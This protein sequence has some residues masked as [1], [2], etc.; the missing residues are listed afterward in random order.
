LLYRKIYERIDTFQNKKGRFSG[1][2]SSILQKGKTMNPLYELTPAN[3]KLLQD[4]SDHFRENPTLAIKKLDEILAT[5][6]NLFVYSF[7]ARVLGLFVDIPK[8]ILD[9]IDEGLS[10]DATCYFLLAQKAQVF[11]VSFLK[12]DPEIAKAALQTAMQCSKQA[13]FHFTDGAKHNKTREKLHEVTHLNLSLEYLNEFNSEF[14]LQNVAYRIGLLAETIDASAKAEK[15]SAK[16]EK[17]SSDAAEAL[18]KVEKERTR[19]IELLGLFTAVIA[20]IFS[21]IHFASNLKT[22]PEAIIAIIGLGA[23][24]LLFLL[25]LHIVLDDIMRGKFHRGFFMILSIVI[26]LILLLVCA[27]KYVGPKETSI[28]KAS[29]PPATESEPVDKAPATTTN[30]SKPETARAR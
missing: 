8:K 2:F 14:S 10:L 25:T 11:S 17:A 19:T 7:K 1:I 21:S 26:V 5:Q 15:A 12:A 9:V 4:A 13:L 20:F 29:K 23:V 18:V 28:S 3:N 27:N 24:L 22:I 16:A 30:A 6:K